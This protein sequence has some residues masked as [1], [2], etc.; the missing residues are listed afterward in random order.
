[1]DP[2]TRERTDRRTGRRYDQEDD[3]NL[4][5]DDE[6]DDD[7]GDLEYLIDGQESREMEDPF[8][9]LLMGS[10]FDK[11]KVTVSYAASTLE[12]VVNMPTDE[13][14]ELSKFAKDNGMSC[15]GTWPREEC[16]NYGKQLQR[17][18]LVCRVV[19]FCEGG[20]RGWQAKDMSG[21]GSNSKNN[22]GSGDGGFN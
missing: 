3:L 18:D 11:P 10:T 14:V 9:I 7:Y 19:P 15:L 20:Q 5:N 21:A 22:A 13:G 1:M 16:L 17:R 2:P 4:N 12:Y 8:H 6:N